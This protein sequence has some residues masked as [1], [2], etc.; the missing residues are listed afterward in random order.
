MNL[1]AGCIPCFDWC[2]GLVAGFEHAKVFFEERV[3]G[4]LE[5]GVFPGAFVDV[6][7]RLRCSW[8]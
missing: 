3:D 2:A 4:V 1:G 6:V 5:V 7:G 8:L